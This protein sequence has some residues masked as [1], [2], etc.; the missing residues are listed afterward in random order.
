MFSGE[1][2]HPPGLLRYYRLWRRRTFDISALSAGRKE[3]KYDTS[4][5]AASAFDFGRINLSGYNREPWWGGGLPR[6]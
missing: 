2:A 4:K 5:S 6:C 3:S 1:F